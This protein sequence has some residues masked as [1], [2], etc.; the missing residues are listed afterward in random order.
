MVLKN[1]DFL[2]VFPQKHGNAHVYPHENTKMARERESFSSPSCLETRMCYKRVFYCFFPKI[3]IRS[4]FARTSSPETLFLPE[5]LHISRQ[6]L[7]KR[8]ATGKTEL[9]QIT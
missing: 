6:K 2:D 7:R 4:C 9:P 1:L 3:E 8:H 5:T